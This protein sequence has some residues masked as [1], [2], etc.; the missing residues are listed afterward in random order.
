[1]SHAELKIG[2]LV[3][4]LP[5]G[6]VRTINAAA[7]YSTVGGMDA[8]EYN[9][10]WRA[11]INAFKT[12]RV[13]LVCDL[14]AVNKTHQALVKWFDSQNSKPYWYWVKVW[15]GEVFEVFR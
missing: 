11:Y 10:S 13:G 7:E 12:K 4:A 9:A 6:T 1:M 8:V 5:N 15:D 14:R 3:R 2:D